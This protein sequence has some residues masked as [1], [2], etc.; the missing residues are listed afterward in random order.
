MPTMPGAAHDKHA[1][2]IFF[3][4]LFAL[5]VEVGHQL[6]VVLQF[7]N[8]HIQGAHTGNAS[9]QSGARDGGVD[10]GHHVF[11]DRDNPHFI[12]QSQSQVDG[13]LK[14]AEHRQGDFFPGG[15][16][17]RVTEAIDKDTVNGSLCRGADS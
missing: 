7:Q 2:M 8:R 4:C 5:L 11:H 1:D 9:F 12:A 10:H 15:S 3:D 6:F 16:H 17:P 14:T 13:G